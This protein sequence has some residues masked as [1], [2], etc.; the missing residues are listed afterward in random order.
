MA[1]DVQFVFEDDESEL[2]HYKAVIDHQA[3]HAQHLAGVAYDDATVG[4][5]T[6]DAPSSPRWSSWQ[7]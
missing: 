7:A 1:T 5:F 2:D 3:N 4:Y 6:R